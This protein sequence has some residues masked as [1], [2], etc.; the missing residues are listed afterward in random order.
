MNKFTRIITLLSII[1][2]SGVLINA[3]QQADDSSK[4]E[5]QL[6]SKK[7]TSELYEI[8][9]LK[10]PSNLNFA[11]ERVPTEKNDIK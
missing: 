2:I 9:A 7:S 1:L 11:G 10:I 4:V 3:K 8:K 6:L 5:Q